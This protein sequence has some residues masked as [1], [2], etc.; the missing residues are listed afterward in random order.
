MDVYVYYGDADK[1][2]EVI[3]RDK[4]FSDKSYKNA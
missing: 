3:M 2:L 1:C 4:I